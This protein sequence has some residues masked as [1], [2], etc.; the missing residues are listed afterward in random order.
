MS[1]SDILR[2]YIRGLIEEVR[3]NPRAGDQLKNAD[4]S[5]ESGEDDSEEDEKEV[6]E[7][8]VS[9]NIAGPTLPLGMKTPGKKKKPGWT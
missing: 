9:A 5:P 3:D 2:R 8:S 4:G 6:D 1:T 7:M